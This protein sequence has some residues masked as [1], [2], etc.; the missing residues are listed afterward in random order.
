Y[1]G[2]ETARSLAVVASG[3]AS[4]RSFMNWDEIAEGE[5]AKVLDHWQ[6]IGQFRRNHPSVGAGKHFT[7]NTKPYVF[8]RKYN[9]QTIDDMVV[10]ALDV[11]KGKKT[12]PVQVFFNEGSMV[13]DAYSGIRSKVI[14]AAVEIDTP[15]DILLLEVSK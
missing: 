2:D 7:L 9:D 13:R 15:F 4:L 11:P 1:Y 12:V 8:A 10:C 5:K 3:D 6:K 14:N